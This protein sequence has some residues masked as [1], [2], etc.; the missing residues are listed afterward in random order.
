[1]IAAPKLGLSAPAAAGVPETAGHPWW[2][3]WSLAAIEGEVRARDE[4]AENARIL[5]G[6][7]R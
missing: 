3:A 5:A 4:L 6:T 1:M 7:R 2:V